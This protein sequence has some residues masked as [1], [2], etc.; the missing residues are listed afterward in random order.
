[1]AGTIIDALVVTLGLDTSGFKKG[2]KEVSDGLDDTRNDAE[3][4]A[5]DMEAAGKRAA[6]FFGSI[7]N[8]IIALAGVSLSLYGVKNFVTEMTSSL[9]QLGVSSKALDMTAKE[10][11]GF[12]G[13]AEAAGSSGE[14]IIGVLQNFQDL[15]TDFRGGGDISN[16]PLIKNLG[17]FEALTG[18]RFDLNKDN[19]GDILTKIANNWG[20]LSKDAQRRF[21]KDINLDN[22]LIQ[23]FGAKG[24]ESFLNRKRYFEEQSK[25]SNSLV[26]DAAK[27][28]VQFVQLKRNFE[29]AGQTLFKAML[30]YLEKIPPL[31]IKLGDWITNHGPEIE[32][33]FSDTAAE[34]QHVAD[35]VGGWE[36]ALKVLLAFVVGSWA[37]GMIGAIGRVATAFGPV[38][39]AMAV[40]SAWDKL[41]QAD[42]EAEKQGISTGEYLVNKMLEKQKA[43]QESGNTPTDKIMQWWRSLGFNDI[44]NTYGAYGT[45]KG[46][47]H[48]NDAYGAYGT[49]TRGLRNNNPGNLNYVGQAGAT[50]EGG[51]NG[52]FAVFETMQQGIAALYKQLQLYFSRGKDTIREIINTYA[53]SSENDTGAY[54]SAIAKK[55]GKGADEI[56]NS[57][58]TETIFNLM[59]GIID[60]ENGQ[61]GKY[62]SDTNILGGIQLGSQAMASRVTP[63]PMQGVSN[64]TDIHIGEMNMQT[65]ASS[66]NAL[67]ADVERTVR[68]NALVSAYNTGQ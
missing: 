52:R 59:R 47:A 64:K 25:A 58:D 24:D 20:K 63:S 2:Q 56:L 16:N 55:L 57:S 15:I 18:V 42:K 61:S 5:K 48:E 62:I 4:T 9:T 51:P 60:H 32:K 34:I 37:I 65:S 43:S 41:G 22:A 23:S 1:M 6:S 33:F 30:P 39:A 29:A 67:G 46:N 45:Q 13:A 54:I 10:L 7:R 11:D 19:S 68:R 49:T 66:V 36:N 12:T 50:K 17:G 38:I 27:L 40:V 3:R 31:L 14:K 44:D 21:G 28:N 53:P 35:M 26:S 8:E